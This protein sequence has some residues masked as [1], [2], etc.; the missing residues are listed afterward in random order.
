MAYAYIVRQG[1][2]SVK[3]GHWR[4]AFVKSSLT[5]ARVYTELFKDDKRVFPSLPRL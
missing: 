1:F 5:L 2:C 4:S 3:R